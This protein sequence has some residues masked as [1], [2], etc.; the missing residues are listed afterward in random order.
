MVVSVAMNTLRR[1][2]KEEPLPPV[3]SKDMAEVRHDSKVV[4]TPVIEDL[5]MEP[6]FTSFGVLEREVPSLVLFSFE[7]HNVL[8]TK[9]TDLALRVLK[10]GPNQQ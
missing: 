3:S 9:V 2:E 10:A 7:I 5:D 6:S 4:R 8:E 1:C